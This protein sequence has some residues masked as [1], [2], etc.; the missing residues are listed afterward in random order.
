[1]KLIINYVDG[2]SPFAITA[3]LQTIL[4]H[5]KI[6]AECCPHAIE[7]IQIVMAGPEGGD[8]FDP[9]NV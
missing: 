2:S 7:S 6:Q 3:P 4:R 8:C 5:I 1:M 9:D